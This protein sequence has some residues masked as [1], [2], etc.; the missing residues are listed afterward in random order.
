MSFEEIVKWAK[1]ENMA[2]NIELKESILNNEDILRESIRWIELP[3]NSHFSSFFEP[4]LKVVKETRPHIET[5]LI[6]TKK[7]DWQSIQYRKNY[8]VIHAHKRYYKPKYLDYCKNYEIGIR[9]YGV[10]GSENYIANP[11]P[12]VIGWITDFPDRVRKAQMK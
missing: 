11:H 10:T 5:A 4:L 6:I 7:F 3:E 9:F 12:A 1:E 2:L 8:D